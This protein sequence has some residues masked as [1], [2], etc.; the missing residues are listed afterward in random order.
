M[1]VFPE[2]SLGSVGDLI[3]AGGEGEEKSYISYAIFGLG[4]VKLYSF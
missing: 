4:N 1:L 3:D 2:Q